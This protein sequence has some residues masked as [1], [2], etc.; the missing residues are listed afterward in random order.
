MYAILTAY[1]AQNLNKYCNKTD[2]WQQSP[3]LC[4]RSKKTIVWVKKTFYTHTKD[5]HLNPK[6]RSLDNQIF[7]GKVWSL[8]GNP[9]VSEVESK[10]LPF[11]WGGYRRGLS[12]GPPKG[13]LKWGIIIKGGSKQFSA[14]LNFWWVIITTIYQLV[15]QSKGK[16]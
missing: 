7:K 10:P 5:D 6:E 8:T 4:A 12:Y 11:V 3:C 14:L 15:L 13:S 2:T 9:G 16:V 1:W